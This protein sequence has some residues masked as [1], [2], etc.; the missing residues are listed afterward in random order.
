M[1]LP[2][3][4]FHKY[5][6]SGGKFSALYKLLSFPV[7]VFFLELCFLPIPRT[8][9]QKQISYRFPFLPSLSPWTSSPLKEM[10]M[11]SWDIELGP[12]FQHLC[13]MGHFVPIHLWVLYECASFNTALEGSKCPINIYTYE[14]NGWMI[15]FEMNIKSS[16]HKDT[17]TTTLF[18]TSKVQQWSN[19]LFVLHLLPKRAWDNYYVRQAY[20]RTI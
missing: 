19:A 8:F 16:R 4:C 18:L 11:A 20:K 13:P 2:T 5:S 10:D 3:S 1:W 14:M 17:I 12:T 15:T 9:M 7:V 6:V